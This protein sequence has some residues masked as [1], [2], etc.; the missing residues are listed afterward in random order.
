MSGLLS[1]LE[2]DYC[3]LY[4]YLRLCHARGEKPDEMAEHMGDVA[5]STIRYHYVIIRRGYIPKSHRCHKKGEQCML[6]IVEE[7][8]AKDPGR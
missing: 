2:G 6:P 3:C 4:G 8:E 1:K 7:L 5:G